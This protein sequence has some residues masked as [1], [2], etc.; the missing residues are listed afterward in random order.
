MADER[1]RRE[2]RRTRIAAAVFSVLFVV[3]F[4]AGIYAW[5]KQQ[6]STMNAR[7][8]NWQAW[9]AEGQRFAAV[10][11]EQRAQE[12]RQAETAQRREAERNAT[13][14]QQARAAEADQRQKAEENA[15]SAQARLEE[16]ERERLRVQLGNVISQLDSVNREISG[17]SDATAR[18]DLESERALLQSRAEEA[19]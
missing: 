8:A 5:Q 11:G 3:A 4:G 12:A 2:L 19:A 17:T 1:R 6:A 15:R 13:V 10:R 14:A 16:A 7:E 18:Q 9:Q